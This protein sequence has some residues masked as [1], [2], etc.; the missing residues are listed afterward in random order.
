MARMTELP[1]VS[2][3]TPSFNQAAFLKDTLRS[4]LTQDYPHIEYIVMDGGSTDG[5]VEIIRRYENRLAYWMSERDGGQADAINKGWR[6]A[7]GDIVAYLNSD[8]TYEPGAVRAAV[9]YLAQHPETDMVYGHCYQ[10]NEH[11]ERVGRLNAIPV[12]I[13]TLLLRNAIMQPTTFFRRH[14]LDR[15][16]LLDLEL[17]HAMD[18][19]LWLRIALRHRI[20]ALNVPLANFRAHDESKSFAKPFVFIQDIRKILS[21]FFANPDLDAS[22]RQLEPQALVNWHM[23]TLLACFAMEQREAGLQIWNEMVKLCPHYWN[24]PEELVELTA[25]TAVHNVETGWGKAQP[26]DG[27]LW[28]QEFLRALP[29]NAQ[30]LR[31]LEPRIRARISVIHAFQAHAQ[32]EPV[33]ARAEIARAWRQ[34]PRL[35]RNR[36]LASVWA[37]SFFGLRQ[38]VTAPGGK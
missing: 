4:V 34:D 23:T 20:D 7:T 26:Q 11:G 16:G 6:R 21:R 17:G 3:V 28:V 1:R 30:P 9:E 8:D 10:V 36:G 15:V 13:R 5:S 31:D 32:H 27:A 14:V 2:I 24:R 18:Y 25:N 22:L 12:N 19:D 33:R 29:A 35:L 37:K 38:S